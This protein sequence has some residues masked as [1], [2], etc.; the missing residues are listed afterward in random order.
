MSAQAVF[1]A[2]GSRASESAETGLDA[3]VGELLQISF[4][5]FFISAG[6]REAPSSS[7]SSDFRFPNF[8]GKWCGKAST[9]LFPRARKLGDTTVRG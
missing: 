7:P 8:K 3:F 4:L 2:G 6:S 5:C 9:L 1:S